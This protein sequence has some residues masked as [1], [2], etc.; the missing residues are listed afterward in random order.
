VAGS[1]AGSGQPPNW[2][3]NLVAHPDV[4]VA[5]RTS[6]GRYRARVVDEAETAALW[7]K[8]DAVY[9][10]FA[11]YRQRTSRVIHIVEL[12]PLPVVPTAHP[13]DHG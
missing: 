5:T 4:M 7:P 6:E 10:T 13:A 12:S 9:P 1:F 8:L 2:Y 3:L 11:T